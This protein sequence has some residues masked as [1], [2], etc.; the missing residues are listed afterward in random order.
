MTAI[1][2]DKASGRAR[3]VWLRERVGRT[4]GA[5]TRLLLLDTLAA[6]GFAGGL[7]GAIPAIPAGTGAVLPWVALVAAAAVARGGAAML[8]LRAGAAGAEQA[9]VALRR[10]VVAA[11]LRR[12]PGA[13]VPPGIW[14]SA[15][16]D[17]VDAVDGYVAR[18]LP[19]RKAGAI[20]PL[21]VLA[22][23]AL[24]SPVA[25]AILAATLLPFIV[26][27]AL[28]GGAAADESRRQ[29][30]ALARLSG[31][32]S[33][34]VR[35]LPVVLAFRAEEREA[36]AI[37]RA[38]AEVAHRT[39]RVLRVAFLSSGGLE[40]FAALSV[41]LVAV[42][43]GF[44]LLG[45]LP[46]TAPE[47]LSLG[48]AFFVLAL[49]PEFY[50]PMRRLAAAYH[51]KQAAETAADRLMTLPE[52]AAAGSAM[53]LP[54][55]TAIVFRDVTVRYPGSDLA[56][57][58]GLTL[59]VAPGETVALLGPSG[60]GKTS[61]LHLLL[62]LAP[63]SG[64][65]VELGGRPLEEFGNVAALAAWAGQHPL[66][67]TGTIR[68]NLLLGN[69]DAS[70]EALDQAV[71]AA[72][73]APMLARRPQG[74]ETMLDAR[75][76]GLSGGERRRLALARALL[77]PAPLLLLDEPTAHLD[78]DAEAALIATIAAACRG[79]TTLIAT[80]SAALAAIAD[81]VVH[82]GDDA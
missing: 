57:V 25:A 35:A 65:S 34:R 11:S 56:V 68:E 55:R 53:P 29:F 60:S 15:A 38:A 61:L 2:H 75:G 47:R 14:V 30:E 76:S 21:I 26:A 8:S 10:R 22:A 77:K 27:M 31:R 33:D 46:F 80:H 37:G 3:A 17:E 12:M 48:E 28:A 19:A 82:L 7:A 50:A 13:A 81:R 32:F 40:F 64:G 71:A 1:S 4:T 54:E 36:D 44:A 39:M 43:C 9:K 23:T 16:V 62:G 59:A 67:V 20:A 6:I 24:A 18:F 72:G 79:R 51:D 52:P 5:S 42:Y 58:H 63:L 70:L 41:A 45:L 69:P 78:R 66:L 74:L 73:L 49:A